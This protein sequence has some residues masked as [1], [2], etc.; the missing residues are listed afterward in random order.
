MR[1]ECKLYEVGEG[2]S[3]KL[4]RTITFLC[5]WWLIINFFF[6]DLIYKKGKIIFNF[7]LFFT[8]DSSFLSIYDINLYV[9]NF[10]FM[11]Y[12]ANNHA[13]SKIH[14]S[15]V[16]KFVELLWPNKCRKSHTSKFVGCRHKSSLVFYLF[17]WLTIK[18]IMRKAGILLHSHFSWR[19]APIQ[20]YTKLIR[21]LS[22]VWRSFLL[23]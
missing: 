7:F 8:F 3:G 13:C 15:F 6:S 22:K 9:F 11:Y 2:S 23:L 14:N 21:H 5:I 16:E 17:F 18:E 1:S 20:S 12:N 4:D 10:F 19:N